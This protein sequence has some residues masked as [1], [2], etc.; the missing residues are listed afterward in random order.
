MPNKSSNTIKLGIFVTIILILFTIGVY[1]IGSKQ[2]LFGST[3]RINTIAYNAYGLQK[4]NNVRYAGINVGSVDEIIFLNDSTL[5]IVMLLEERVKEVIKK[6]AIASIG[7]D[8]LVGNSIVN[9]SP[10][11]VASSFVDEGDTLPSLGRAETKDMLNALD[12]SSIHLTRITSNLLEIT[13]KLNDGSGTLSLLLNDATTSENLA[14]AITDFRRSSAQISEFSASLQNTLDEAV[15]GKGLLGYVLHDTSFEANINQLSG[16]LDSLI[17]ERTALMMQNIEASS[18]SISES[19]ANLQSKIEQLNLDEGLVGVI[20]KDSVLAE[21]F[22]MIIHNLEQGTDNFQQSMEA[23]KHNF[24]LRR[25]FKKLEKQKQKE[26]KDKAIVLDSS[27]TS[28]A[29]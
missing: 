23:L 2:N 8:G 15:H 14:A 4:G 25:Y 7:S 3:F 21:E 9:I 11:K 26:M 19:S 20:M 18:Q 22:R 24:L 29:G 12:Q 6:N 28:K 10:G 13:D 17:N 27:F 5:Q 1:N 16:S